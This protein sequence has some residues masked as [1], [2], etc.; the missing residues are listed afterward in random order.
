MAAALLFSI[1]FSFIVG[2]LAGTNRHFEKI[3][4]PVLDILQSIPILGFFPLAITLFVALLPVIGSE[5][6]A[7][8]LI[9]TSQVWN[10]TFAVYEGTR[11]IKSELLDTARFL[12]ISWAEKFRYLYIPATLPRVLYNLQPSWANGI[13]FLVGSEILTFGETEI[14]LFGLGTVISRYTVNGDVVGIATTV[15]MLVLA[16]VLT[17]LLVFR[18]LTHVAEPRRKARKEL[19]GYTS[20]LRRIFGPALKGVHLPSH[21][22]FFEYHKAVEQLTKRVSPY[23]SL[24]RGVLFFLLGGLLVSLV[25][26]GSEAWITRLGVLIQAIQ[27]LGLENLALSAVYSLGRVAAAVLFSIA[28]SVP[29]AIAIARKERL[30]LYLTSFLQVIASIPAT[31]VYPIFAGTLSEQPELRAFVMTVA[32]TQYYVFFQVYAGLKNIPQTE[33]ELVELLKLRT[34]DRV[35]MVYLPRALPPLVTGCITAAG[36]AWNSLIVSERI[37]LGDVVAETPN[38]GLGKLLSTMTYEGNLVGS[39]VVITLM[40][41][42]IVLM[43]RLFW[44][45]VYDLVISRLKIQ[46]EAGK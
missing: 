23:A 31:I 4:I 46:E 22:L 19:L 3:A 8:F 11:L 9:F 7:I 1:L 40:A 26:V 27:Y 24:M 29:V 41:S 17:T 25:V 21:L 44:K 45:R 16:T 18:P 20:F 12:G 15:F 33:L 30:S 43:N 36:G 37:V 32:A 38:P 2:T 5:L 42:L 39:V 6:A 35:R 13:F 34:V 28:W 10:I 14:E